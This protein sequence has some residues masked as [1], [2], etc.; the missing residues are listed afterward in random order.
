MVEMACSIIAATAVLNNYCRDINIHQTIDED[1]MKYTLEERHHRRS[2]N[3]ACGDV[4]DEL[5]HC[6]STRKSIVNE[7]FE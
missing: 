3:Y 4:Q 5:V 7:Y 2:T 1:V 6:H